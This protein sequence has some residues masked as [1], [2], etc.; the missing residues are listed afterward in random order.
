MVLVSIR[1]EYIRVVRHKAIPMTRSDKTDEQSAWTRGISDIRLQR[2]ERLLPPAARPYAV[3]MRLDRPVGWWLLFWPGAF[4]LTLAPDRPD[5][6]GWPDWLAAAVPDLTYLLLFLIGAVVMRG[7]GCVINDLFDRDL[8]AGVARTAG[9]PLASGAVG[10]PQATAFLSVL[11][12]IGLLILLQFNTFAILIGAASLLLI[13]PYP[14][15]KRI[16]YWPQAWL[17]ITF[18]WGALLGFAVV[19]GSLS[20]G[21]AFL[22]AGCVFWTLGYDTVYAHQDKADDVLIGVK[23]SALALGKQSRPVLTLFFAAQLLLFAAAM[24]LAGL[25]AVSWL[26]LTPAAFLM[27]RQ[28]NRLDFDDPAACLHAFKQHRDIGA[29]LWAAILIGRG[30]GA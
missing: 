17:G 18:N 29:L 9:R 16:T 20:P 21:A 22:Y 5:R 2:I 19:E 12:G 8:D 13:V 15:M 28:A 25:P 7:A 30:L 1:N 11:L 4:A 23:S 3:L 6:P 27:L 10:T 14:L 24:T 26:A